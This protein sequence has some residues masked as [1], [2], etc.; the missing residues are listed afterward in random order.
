MV[1]ISAIIITFNEEKN[2]LRALES[3]RPVADEIVVVDSMSSD[4]T[5]SIC[6]DFG[7]RVFQR[8][9]DGYGA[10][11]QF[12]VDRA[13]ND[14]VL[15]I[16]ADEVMTVPLQQEIRSLFS[17]ENGEG[18]KAMPFAG[19]LIPRSLHFL[20]K[21][22]RHG[23]AGGEMLLRLFDRTKGSFT[24]APV[25]EEVIVSGSTGILKGELVHYSYRD[26]SHHVEKLNTY[27]SL[28]AEEYVK[29][30]KRFPKIWP[31]LKFPTAF[32]TFYILKGGILDGYPG[33]MWSFMAAVYGALKVAKTI[34]RSRPAFPSATAE[35]LTGQP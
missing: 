20:G 24:T 26:I 21:I 19:Y 2:I 4:R 27:T 34:E 16:D 8:E 12:A 31:A 7:C 33:F 13:S 10:Q 22:L 32:F 23:G 30:H 28:A 29:K 14:W 15:W 11:K 1:R 6:R 25:H 18:T 35:N 9:F 5:V 3:V 17:G